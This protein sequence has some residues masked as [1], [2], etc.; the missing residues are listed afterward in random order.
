MESWREDVVA[1]LKAR[2]FFLLLKREGKSQTQDTNRE[3]EPAPSRTRPPRADQNQ[4][5]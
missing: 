3:N 4:Q 2:T 5:H 1:F